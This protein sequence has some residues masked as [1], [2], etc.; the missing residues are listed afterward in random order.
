MIEEALLVRFEGRARRGLGVAVVG[1][2]V[3]A[4]DV[5][6]LQRLVQVLVNDLEGVGIGVVDTDLF[7]GQLVLDDLVF[8][9]LERQG[10]GGVEAERLEIAGEHLHGG[11]AA[12]F[13]GRDKIGAGRER[14]ITGAPEAEPRGIGEVLHRRGARRRDIEDA[15]VMQRVLQAQSGLALLRWFLVAAFPFVAGGVRHS[16]GLVEDDDAIKAC[17]G[18]RAGAAAQPVDDLLNPA[19]LLAARLGAQGGVGREQDA[20]INRDRRTLAE[21]RQWHEVGAVAADCRPVALG[22][23]DQLVGFGDPQ[24]GA[25]P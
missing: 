11:D 25:V 8:D 15:G 3:A 16:M 1:A 19:G 21:A 22:V 18:P 24:R 6:G 2:A 23:L 14:K 4:A 10:A 20:L 9:P 5:G 13:H 17:P 12:F 7:R